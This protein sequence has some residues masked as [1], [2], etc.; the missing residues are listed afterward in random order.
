MPGSSA[1]AAAAWIRV[2]AVQN[3]AAVSAARA[4]Y[5]LGAGETS[6]VQLD[7]RR[8]REY[9]THNG[10]DVLG[11]AGLLEALFRR[12]VIVDLRKTYLKLLAVHARID[13]G[14]LR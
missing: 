8:G 14:T 11:C 1:I 12:G 2:A 3:A 10:L 4:Q 9:A 13:L 5:G 6:A 7:E